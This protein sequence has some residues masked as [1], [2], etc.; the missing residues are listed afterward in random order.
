MASIYLN[1]GDQGLV[2]F[3]TWK[4]LRYET[5]LLISIAFILAGFI[6]QYFLFAIFPGVILILAGNLLLLPAGI[7]NLKNLGVFD[8]ES[9]WEKVEARKLDEYLAL[10][11]KIRKWDRS[12]IDAS[13]ILGGFIFIILLLGIVIST[14]AAFV[15]NNKIMTIAGVDAMV[16][17]LPYWLTG[18]RSIY[19]V[20]QL[21]MK[22][23]LVKTLMEKVEARLQAHKVEYYFMLRGKE[24]RIPM[25]V[26]FRVNIAGQSKDFLGFYGQI[27]INGLSNG[28]PYPYFYVVLVA[29]KGFG[30]ANALELQP[31]DIKIKKEF[32]NQDDVEVLVIRQNTDTVSM[33]YRTTAKQVE[34]VFLEGLALAEKIA[35][36]VSVGV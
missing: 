19:T 14:L 25:D 31:P 2:V 20:S 16:L 29:R 3:K 6:S 23:K 4:S 17:L 9:N 26:K 35:V 24:K 1:P 36:G 22:V 5:R 18:F 12:T 10:D 34:T 11:R 28:A 33:G 8:P 21:T 7:T 30:L 13:N 27:T 32:K 15:D